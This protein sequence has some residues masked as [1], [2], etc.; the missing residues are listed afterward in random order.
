M[1]KS[2]AVFYLPRRAQEEIL[3][4]AIAFAGEERLRVETNGPN[5]V[6]LSRGSIWWTGKRVVT[7][8]AWNVPG[9]ANVHVEVWVVEGLVTLNADP[10]VFFGFVPRRA[11]WR[12]VS[13]F[14]S[15]LGVP[16]ESVFVHY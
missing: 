13:A 11:A 7:V 12:T 1:G 3:G 9:G 16:P 6:H 15:R 10:N 14:V 5:H 4:A 8:V 2:V